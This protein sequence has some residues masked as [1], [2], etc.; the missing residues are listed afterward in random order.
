MTSNGIL[1]KKSNHKIT[2][3]PHVLVVDDDDRI[4]D[5]VKQ[6]LIENLVV[7]N[8]KHYWGHFTNKDNYKLNYLAK[9]I[10]DEQLFKLI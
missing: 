10:S 1:S 9:K 3:S 6:Y 4:R 8:S 2:F 5:L 7:E